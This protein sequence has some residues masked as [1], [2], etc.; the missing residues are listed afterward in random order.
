MSSQLKLRHYPGALSLRLAR[1]C[2]AIRARA[3]ELRHA[4][5][6][7]R[8]Y[9]TARVPSQARKLVGVARGEA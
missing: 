5:F 8:R 1:T 2:Y 3:A 4:R 9:S 7:V 6:M